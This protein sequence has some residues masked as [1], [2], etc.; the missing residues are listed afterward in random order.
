MSTD[1]W[2]FL[3]IAL[4]QSAAMAVAWMEHRSKQT[5][6]LADMKMDILN[7]LGGYEKLLGE[8]IEH[9]P[10]CDGGCSTIALGRWNEQTKRPY[11]RR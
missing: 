9:H 5:T 8:H 3:G 10:P 11:K 1:V 6:T 2:A 7:R 4:T